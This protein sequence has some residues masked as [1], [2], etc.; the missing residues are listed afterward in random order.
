MFRFLM[1]QP[2]SEPST[3]VCSGG[4]QKNSFVSCAGKQTLLLFAFFSKQKDV[5]MRV[6][7]FFLFA[8]FF[9]P[10]FVVVVVVCGSS[11]LLLLREP[12]ESNH[13][14]CLTDMP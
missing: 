2:R 14:V 8:F 9:S 11:L 4:D 13:S 10:F 7:F 3:A 1:L 6:Y 12:W 5:K